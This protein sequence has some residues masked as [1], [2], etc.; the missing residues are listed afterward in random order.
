MVNLKNIQTEVDTGFLYKILSEN[1][2]DPNVARVFT[3]MSE[4]EHSHALAFLK[5]NNLDISHLPAPSGRARVLRLIGKIFGYDYILGVL[6]D[7]E[8]SISSSIVKVK[9][10][11]NSTPS[12]S[13]TSHVTILK[14]IL[15]NHQDIS[16]SNLA[17]FEKRHRSVGGNALRA[18]VLGGNDGLVSNFSLVMGIAGATSGQS[19]VLLT[20]LAGLMA[21]ALSMALGEWISVKSSQELYENQIQLEMEELETN[22]EGEEK[23][24]A[25]IYISKGIPESQARSMAKDIISDKDR[26][27]EMLIQEELG[28]NV[29]D[30]KGSAM[31]AAITSFLLFAIG[32]IIPVIPFFF[33]SGINAVLLSAGFSAMGLFLIGA[34]ITLF[35]GKSIWFSGFR[36]V[37]FGLAAAAI[38]YGIGTIIGV[39]LG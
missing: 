14:N 21:G 36:Q 15:N 38:T 11:S 37:F 17:R 23:E 35:T 18:A 2:K 13:D 33:L 16:G 27:H 30:L 19:E 7:T 1:E 10:K 32:A 5:K 34:A 28:I 8:K 31:E 12:L 25:L 3:E 9:R 29:E 22:P 26:A 24:L 6:L 39:S 4:I 20:G